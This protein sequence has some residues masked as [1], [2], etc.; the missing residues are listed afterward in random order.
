V[1]I[2]VDVLGRRQESHHG[3]PLT[4]VVEPWCG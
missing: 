1:G 4:T 2:A 3:R